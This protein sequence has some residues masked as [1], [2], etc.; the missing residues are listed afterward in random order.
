MQKSDVEVALGVQIYCHNLDTT[1]SAKNEVAA[2][3]MGWCCLDGSE[4]KLEVF[5]NH[6]GKLWQ[7][8]YHFEASG[9]R[10]SAESFMEDFTAKYGPPI[11]LRKSY[12]NGLGNEVSGLE[13][14]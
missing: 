10:E 5:L 2:K 9:V 4:P 3:D 7:L 13:Y 8:E 6:M 12:R 11:T 1:V 14:G